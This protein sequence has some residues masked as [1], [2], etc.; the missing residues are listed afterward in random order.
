ML[1]EEGGRGGGGR[2]PA[3]YRPKLVIYRWINTVA[4]S[5]AVFWGVGEGRGEPYMAYLQLPPSV[6]HSCR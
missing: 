1:N 2:G 5:G 4:N 6:E 3:G